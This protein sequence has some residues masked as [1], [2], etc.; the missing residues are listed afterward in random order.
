MKTTF[1]SLLLYKS[2]TI[3]NI[4]G[5]SCAFA[6]FMIISMQIKYDVTYNR[7]NENF[8]SIYQLSFT[9]TLEGKRQ[10]MFN[11]QLPISFKTDIPEIEHITVLNHIYDV[12]ITLIGNGEQENNTIIEPFISCQED[13]TKIF[14]FDFIQGDETAFKDPYNLIVSEEFAKKWYNDKSPIGEKISTGNTVFTIAAIIKTLPKNSTLSANIFRNMGDENINDSSEWNYRA[15]IK[16]N[17]NCSKSSLEEKLINSMYK[18]NMENVAYIADAIPLSEIRYV[19]G[20]YDKNFIYI[21]IVIALSIVLLAAINFINFATSMVPLKIKGINLRKV[22]GATDTELRMSVIWEAITL[23][24]ISFII[25]LGAVDIFKNSAFSYLISDVSWENNQ[26]VY[27]LAFGIMAIT[28]VVSG[29]YPA[30][31]STSF[32]PALVLKSSYAMSASGVKFRKA[33]IG[34]QF[35]IALSFIS[36]TIFIQLQH[37]FLINRDGGYVKEGIIHVSHGWGWNKHEMLKNEL[38]QNTQIKDIAFS[39]D[40]FGTQMGVMGWGRPYS[41]GRINIS[42]IPVSHNFLDFFEI[43]IDSG[44]N[45]IQ[46]DELS[47]NGYFIMSRAAMDKFQIPLGEKI[48]GHR[49]PTD[50]IGICENVHITNMKVDLEPYAFYIFG[51]HPWQPLPHAYIKVSGN[52]K[53]IFEHIRNSY[54]KVDPEV[55]IDMNYLTTELQGAYSN[56]NTTK[57]IMQAF[58]FIAIIIALVG[59]FGLVSFDTKF[60]KKE[61]GLRRIN[62]ATVNNILSMFSTAYIKIVLISFILSVPVV[63]YLVTQWINSFPYKIEIYWW[64]FILSLA[65][66]LLL[67]TIISITQTLR[68]ARENPINSIKN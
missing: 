15:Y 27:Y 41:K 66:V 57:Q 54:T 11:R 6:T 7:Q 16:L 30:F 40:A 12:K 64:V 52:S 56:E 33:L 34:F 61:I 59:V 13:I 62:G 14:T 39:R 38:L 49:K 63:Y 24:A 32:Q 28:G 10:I 4:I 68:I 47:E 58:S 31:Y 18:G 26:V 43:K 42:S 1:K 37:N 21:M 29:L 45:F 35:F 60:R 22:V 2:S 55:I 50:I 48:A 20:G 53:Q 46:N 36:A 67:T 9:D 25:A 44:R 23:S 65:M 51:K 19:D 17:D 5:L 8:S 3:L